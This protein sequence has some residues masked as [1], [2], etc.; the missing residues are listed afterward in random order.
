MQYRIVDSTNVYLVL[1]TLKYLRTQ[2]DKISC[3]FI[4]EELD[5]RVLEESSRNMLR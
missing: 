4:P 2:D 1:L 3:L 5:L